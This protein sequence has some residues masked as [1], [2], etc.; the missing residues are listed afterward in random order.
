MASALFLVLWLAAGPAASDA[1]SAVQGSSNS[2]EECA[3]AHVAG[4]AA[5]HPGVAAALDGW[6]KEKQV[7]LPDAVK[8]RLVAEYLCVES[9][10]RTLRPE[11]SAAELREVGLEV[12]RTYLNTVMAGKEGN[13]ATVFSLRLGV[14]GL[15]HPEPRPYRPLKIVTDPDA[16]SAALDGTEVPGKVC[17]ATFGPHELTAEHRGR[18]PCRKRIEVPAGSSQLVVHCELGPMP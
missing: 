13:L 6:S 4:A 14:G 15:R 18:P 17:L 2:L 1:G 16:A 5:A 12:A 10:L 7:T 3:G 11:T 9:H 8:D